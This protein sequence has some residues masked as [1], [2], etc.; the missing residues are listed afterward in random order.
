M[1]SGERVP[2]AEENECI[3]R[4]CLDV[5]ECK[6]HVE[7][8]RMQKRQLMQRRKDLAGVLQVFMEQNE[9]TPVSPCGWAGTNC[10]C[11]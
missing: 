8:V 3:G 10:T 4:F 5:S 6:E 2:T 1:D 7:K 11:A 9:A